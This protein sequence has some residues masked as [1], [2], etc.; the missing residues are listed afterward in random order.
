MA[1]PMP[2][3]AVLPAGLQRLQLHSL[4]D[5]VKQLT[6]LQVRGGVD[7]GGG[8]HMGHELC[9]DAWNPSVQL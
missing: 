4:K 1:Q 5:S 3:E 7:A 6:H 2:P 9:L 8:V